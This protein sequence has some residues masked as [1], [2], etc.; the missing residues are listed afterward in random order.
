MDQPLSRLQRLPDHLVALAGTDVDRVRQETGRGRQRLAISSH[1]HEWTT[2]D[3]NWVNEAVARSYH[4][5]L[6]RLADLHV[7]GVRGRKG[8]AIEGEE[9]RLR[10]IHRHRRIGQPFALEPFLNLQR[11]LVI[12][13]ERWIGRRWIDE[14]R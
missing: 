10:T 1:H 4:P 14:E 12:G 5:Q 13:G 3:V 11:V 2:V 6:Q 9:V 8:L 7:K